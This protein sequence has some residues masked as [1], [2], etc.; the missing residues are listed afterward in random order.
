MRS[1]FDQFVILRLQAVAAHV[2]GPPRPDQDLEARELRRRLR[3]ARG[4]R[5][6]RDR[7]RR[8][9]LG[10]GHR[11]PRPARQRTKLQGIEPNED[12]SH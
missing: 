3:G 6:H 11:Q 7:R 9:R 4:R 8:R 1:S 12:I 10:Q 5:H 2:D